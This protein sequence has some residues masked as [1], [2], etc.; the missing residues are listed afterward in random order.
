MKVKE[1][2]VKLNDPIDKFLPDS[3]AL[4]DTL[5]SVQLV[6][7]ASHSSGLRRQ[8]TN[9]REGNYQAQNPYRHYD[10]K[11]L[12][13]A[14]R[15][16]PL[17]N[18]P[19]ETFQYSNFG[20]A[21]LG[22]LL[23]N[24]EGVSYEES[25]KK[26]ILSP[27]GMHASS[28]YLKSDNEANGYAYTFP[29]SHWEFDA[30]AGAGALC[31]NVHD[32]LRFLSAQLGFSGPSLQPAIALSQDAYFP[33][34]EEGDVALGWGRYEL[35]NGDIFYRHNGGTG[36]F[37]SFV[38]YL[39][40]SKQGVV[41]CTNSLE[42]VDDLGLHQLVDSFDLQTDKKTSIALHVSKKLEEEAKFSDS[43]SFTELFPYSPD[44][45]NSDWGQLNYL[46]YTYLKHGETSK[47]IQTFSWNT[48]LYPDN[49][50]GYD[51]LGDGYWEA[52]QYIEAKEA[53]EK[54][55]ALDPGY[56][57]A[58]EMLEKIKPLLKNP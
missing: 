36:G 3:L 21:L 10:S 15:A 29:V 30:F 33:I 16:E 13:K 41:V 32:M 35:E 31:S 23:A 44:S 18:K 28:G 52:K 24:Q 14:L 49:A 37:R 5:G 39:S 26:H 17:V 54:T 8:P 1:G 9:L 11:L 20:A 56:E 50:D 51:S 25:L 12:M 47:A 53:Y 34:S 45:V 43:T 22:Y 58:R 55:L 57:H 4:S 42:G 48:E 46:G 2:V 40:Q 7:L 38:G 27:L 6:Q 19:G